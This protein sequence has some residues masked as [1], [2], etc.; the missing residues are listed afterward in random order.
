MTPAE[1]GYRLLRAIQ[2]RVERRTLN[3]AVPAPDLAYCGN[4]WIAK[5]PKVGASAYVEAAERIA[6]GWLDVYALRG[7]KLG[8][9]PRW[10]RDPKSGIE[11]PPAYGKLLDTGDPDLVG[12]V[13]YLWQPNRHAHVVTLAK[14]HALTKKRLYLETI[15]EHLDSW[16]LACPYGIGPNWASALEVSIRLV[17]WSM[18]WQLVADALGEDFRSR[19]LRSV[20]QHCAFIRGWFTLHAS[21]AHQLIGEAAGLFIA[22]LTW[23]HWAESRGWAA[24][25]K[26][27]LEREV[28][29]QTSSDGVS[30]EQSIGVHAFVLERLLLC[31]LAGKANGQ[32]FSP[33]LE[34]RVEAMLD[35][36]ASVTDVGGHVPDFGDSDAE[37]GALGRSLLATGAIIFKR[38]D[39]KVKARALDDGTRWLLG[40]DADAQFAA[41]DVEAT[42]LPLRQA[43]PEGGY[44]VAGCAFDTPSEIRLVIDAGPAGYRGAAAHGHADALSFTL[45]IGG[46]EFLVDPGTYAFHTQQ[47]WRR[48]FRGTAAHNTLRIDALD[49]SVRARAGCS[50]WLSSPDKD[51]FEGWHD[52][53]MRLDDPVKHRRLVELDK[54]ARRIVVEDTLEMGEEHD[55]ELFFHLSERCR[56]DP[57]PDDSFAVSHDGREMRVTL[58]SLAGASARIDQ[59]NLAP[60]QGWRSPAF[61]TRV[62]AP[63]IVW[64]ARL[65]GS[66][67]LRTEIAV[68]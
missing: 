59:G 44:F 32:W 57:C 50:L 13:K 36:L 1:L 22:A 39:F 65:A 61:D 54:V 34:S 24:T 7:I 30:R 14:A 2:A 16:F 62:A 37:D 12:D 63:V 55:V 28:V 46:K 66:V 58:P 60:L 9:P 29:A 53:Y 11:A 33:D 52:G 40:R 18:A 23:P 8:Y 17:N 10:N 25:A 35:F 19:W 56:V 41:L 31:L 5:E 26:A 15:E 3:R 47:A 42:R 64:Q 38:G 20:Y 6:Q 27:V 21:A 68:P 45:S 67:H 43:F 4:A 48:Y 51:T 49:Q